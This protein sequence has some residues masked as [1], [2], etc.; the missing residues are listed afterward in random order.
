MVSNQNSIVSFHNSSLQ[1]CC[2]QRPARTM[3]RLCCYLLLLLGNYVVC[4]LWQK[5]AQWRRSVLDMWSANGKHTSNCITL[6][7]KIHSI[8]IIL[9]HDYFHKVTHTHT[10]THILNIVYRVYKNS[11]S[12]GCMSPRHISAVMRGHPQAV[13]N[14]HHEGRTQNTTQCISD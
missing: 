3:Y 14:K 6:H 10:N 9:I 13:R 2:L 12:S 7:I 11:F 4:R 1:Y 8:L 5:C